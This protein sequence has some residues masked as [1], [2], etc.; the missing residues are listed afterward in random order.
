MNPPRLIFDCHLDI[1]MNA[2]EFNRDQRWTLEKLRR[3]ELT[4]TFIAP[5]GAASLAQHGLLSRAAAARVGIIVATQIARYSPRFHNLPGWRSPEQ[6]WAQTQG[7]LA[8]YRTMEE[9]GEMVQLRT[10]ADV[11]AHA[12][13]WEEGH[14][15]G[16]HEIAHRL[17][18]QPGRGGF[19]SVLAA[20]GKVACRGADRAG[21]A[22]IMGRAFM[23]T[24]PM[25][26]ALSTE[27]GASC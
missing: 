26:R 11:E 17:Y 2:M 1:S 16:G 22:P 15:R 6:A 25:T 10:W 12:A 7:Q 14:S 24:G 27:R 3:C 8:Y 13:R 20:L 18:S 19:R 23:G 5:D 9:C 21:A 4:S